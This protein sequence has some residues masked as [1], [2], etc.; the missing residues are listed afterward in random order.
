MQTQASIAKVIE[1]HPRR[2]NA[3]R[4]LD[5]IYLIPEDDARFEEFVAKLIREGKSDLA[6]HILI[7]K[8]L[9]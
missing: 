1:P 8:Q 6:C 5:A 9:G 3:E 4:C 2:S 7:L